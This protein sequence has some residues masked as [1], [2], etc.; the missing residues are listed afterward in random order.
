MKFKANTI[1]PT[2]NTNENGQGDKPSQNMENTNN[3]R[4]DPPRRLIRQAT[5]P[6]YRPTGL[7]SEVFSAPMKK[8]RRKVLERTASDSH[9]DEIE[10][11]DIMEEILKE[12]ITLKENPVKPAAKKS[13]RS[14]TPEFLSI[15]RQFS[16]E[17]NCHVDGESKHYNN[18]TA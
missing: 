7:P 4:K 14:P 17:S 6:E 8:P 9:T 18:T 13:V 2:V 15:A 12:Q 1:E 11:N 3:K 5:Q 16:D 10:Y